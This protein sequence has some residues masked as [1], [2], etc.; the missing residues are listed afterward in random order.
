MCIQMK[1]MPLSNGLKSLFF[2][3]VVSKTDPSVA[4]ENKENL[5]FLIPIAPGMED[6]EAIRKIFF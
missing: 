3:L 2:M 4:P 5:F 6:T 1:F